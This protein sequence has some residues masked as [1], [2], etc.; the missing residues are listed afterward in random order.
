[1]AAKNDESRSAQT[2]TSSNPTTNVTETV[3]DSF[4]K[5]LNLV[6]TTTQAPNGL[7]T[8]MLLALAAGGAVLMVFVVALAKR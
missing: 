3:A 5:T 4:N 2:T 1:M 7:P 6:T 8:W